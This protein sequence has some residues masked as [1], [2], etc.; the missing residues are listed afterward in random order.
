MAITIKS[1]F[2][3][4]LLL[5]IIFLASAC[6]SYEQRSPSNRVLNYHEGEERQ[7][8]RERGRQE[9]EKEE[10]KWIPRHDWEEDE[11][12][13]R[14]PRRER[15]RQEGEK[16]EEP[17]E[18]H[19]GKWRPSH[20]WEEDEEEKR[21]DEEWRGSRRYEDPEERARLRHREE[22]REKQQEKE[23][24]KT[25]RRRH[26]GSEEEEEEEE[27]GSSSESQGRRNPFFFRSNKF[28]TLFENEN[29]HIRLLQ[30]FDKRSNLFQNLQNYRLVEYKA[31]PHAIFLPH[32]IDADFILV[33]L[34]GKAILTVLNPNNRNS[35]NLERG[36][37]IKL[38]A[39][40][41]A[42]VVNQDDNEDLRIADLVIPIN[43]PGK[44][45]S[46]SPSRSQNQQSYFRGFSKNILEASFN[47]RYEDIEK[48]LLE[49]EPQQRR[50]HKQRQQSQEADAIVRVSREQIKELRRH[51]K[52]S[53][54]K[55]AASSE[56]EPFNLRN[57][58]PIYSNKFGK[59]FETNP[60]KSPQLKDLDISVSSVDINEGA[61]LLP[62]Y[63]SRAVVVLLV[64]EGKGN[65]EL[66]GPNNEQQEQEED[67]EE[68]QE[69]EEEQDQNKR[70]QR[71]KARLSRGDVVVIPAGYPHAIKA[72]SDLYLLGFGINAENNQRN[73]LAGE[74]DNVIS[75]IER[76]VKEIAFPGSAQEVDRLIKNQKQSHFANARPEEESQKRRGPLSSILAT[77]Y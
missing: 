9:G 16:E 55:S 42:Y 20:E 66:V 68:Q 74:E 12:E 8:Q 76:P 5:G 13:E 70:I 53:S 37:T 39:G 27:E 19:S 58:N 17:R 63:N 44:F 26:H 18:K 59:F 48:V 4:L 54:K 64:N 34:S 30:R 46:F 23:W 2:P 49:E 45:Q 35:F 36:D 10:E 7:P 56:S 47:A 31:R 24:E 29:G 65:L 32:H 38:P 67:E 1:R 15:S 43:R 21:E 11:G 52:P 22:R 57:R 33:V 50:G 41:T 6:A 25:D 72:S 61:L 14:Q 60:E 73:F 69:W 62:H 75:Q 3:L 77:F 40:T 71:Y 51:A 28:Q